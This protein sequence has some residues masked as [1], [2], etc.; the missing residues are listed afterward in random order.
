MRIT[1]VDYTEPNCHMRMP[2]FWY[3]PTNLRIDWYKYPLR[4]SYSNREFNE[5]E[6]K[7]IFKKY[8]SSLS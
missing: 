6:L 5:S 7:E 3:K 1:D 4:D 8:N 2:N